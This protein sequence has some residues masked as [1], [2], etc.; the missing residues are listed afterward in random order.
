[1]TT[2]KKSYTKIKWDLFQ[3]FKIDIQYLQVNQHDT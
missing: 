2:F 3:E 1:M